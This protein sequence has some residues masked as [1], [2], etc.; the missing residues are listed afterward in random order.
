[1]TIESPSCQI[2]P[3][4]RKE[5]GKKTMSDS[6]M[7]SYRKTRKKTKRIRHRNPNHKVLKIK[8]TTKANKMCNHKKIISHYKK[9][10]RKKMKSNI[11]SSRS[12]YNN[13]QIM[14]SII[15]KQEKKINYFYYKNNLIVYLNQ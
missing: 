14:K 13:L 5:K 6:L 2:I 9:F 10:K 1:M 11:K 12:L 7:K 15:L 8:N 4:I 3:K